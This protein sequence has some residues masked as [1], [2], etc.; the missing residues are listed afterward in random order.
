VAKT[1]FKVRIVQNT[2]GGQTAQPVTPA[3]NAGAPVPQASKPEAAP[4]L[5]KNSGPTNE[6]I[7]T[8][9]ANG[10]RTGQGKGSNSAKRRKMIR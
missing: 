3:A 6:Q 9:G 1:V 2:E 10:Q 4:V 8:L 7:R 5:T